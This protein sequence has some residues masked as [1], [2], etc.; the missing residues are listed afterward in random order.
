MF[1]RPLIGKPPGGWGAGDGG[2]ELV[3]SLGKSFPWAV[4]SF[5]ADLELSMN[6]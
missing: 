3:E 6:L 1:E 5:F 2:G 4:G